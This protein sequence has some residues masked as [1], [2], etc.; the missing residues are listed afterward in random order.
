M[1]PSAS[2]ASQIRRSS[3]ERQWNRAPR[4]RPIRV[5]P[6]CW[7]ISTPQAVNPDREASTG[8]PI[9][10]VLITISEVSRPVV[11]RILSSGASPSDSIHPAILSTAL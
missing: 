4:I 5:S 9:S 8:I 6:T 2:G 11:Y 3:P 10:A 7:A 1:T